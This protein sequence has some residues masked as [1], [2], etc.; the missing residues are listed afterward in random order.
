MLGRIPVPG[1]IMLLPTSLTD[2]PHNHAAFPKNGINILMRERSQM[3]G[4]LEKG[5]VEGIF[6]NL[7]KQA[8]FVFFL[9]KYSYFGITCGAQHGFS[10]RASLR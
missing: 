10:A 3:L 6:S 7:L 1:F 4:L 2:Y 9:I 5:E 8:Y